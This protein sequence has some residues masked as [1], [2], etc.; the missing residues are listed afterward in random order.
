[1]FTSSEEQLMKRPMIVAFAAAFAFAGIAAH[2]AAPVNGNKDS[3]DS[4]HSMEMNGMTGMHG[5]E[6]GQGMSGMGSM[7]EMMQAC[8]MM[9][10][11]MAMRRQASRPGVL[12]QLPPGN[13]KLQLQMQAEIMQKVGEIMAK[14]AAQLK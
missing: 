1:M 9:N 6:H 11:Q 2:A 10:G 7:M 13:E 3:Q 5:M 8:P 14:Y 12:P 4:R